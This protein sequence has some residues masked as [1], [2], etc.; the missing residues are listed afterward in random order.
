MSETEKFGR[1]VAVPRHRAWRAA[2]LGG[3]ALGVAT[4]V[5]AGRARGLISGEP[6]NLRDL[7]VTPANI[8][9][10]TNELARMRGAAMKL[11]QL[12]SMDAGDILPPELAQIMAR[13]RA[14]ADFMPPSQ[15]K[16]VLTA[17]WGSDWL[18]GFK[19]FN[20]RPIAAASIGQVH[21]ATL[22]DGRDVAIKV[23]YP[24]VAAS[25]D[26]DVANVASLIRLSGLLPRGFEIDRYVEEARLQ[27]HEETDYLREADHLRTFKGLLG[28]S[29][30]YELPDVYDDLTVPSVLTMSFVES[31]PL[32]AAERCDQATR[33]QIA[34][35]VVDLALREL[36][37][38][39]IVQTDPNFA[40][41]R[42][43]AD[44]GKLVLLDFGATR[45]P[46]EETIETY[47]QLIRAG[48]EDDSDALYGVSQK[49]GVWGADSAPAHVAQLMQMMRLVFGAINENPQF[50]FNDRTL[51]Q[52]LNREGM[53]LAEAGFVPPPVSAD[54]L[55]I[56]RKLAGV[57]LIA[58]NLKATLPVRDMI[59]RRI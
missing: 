5:A 37:E 33:N 20:V 10:V 30:R 6:A 4:N 36:F 41:F 9:R 21:R 27:L 13:L 24:G 23:Q 26:S 39:G 7:I 56:Q 17:A 22:R 29:E 11:G 44:S 34:S 28:R 38:F 51:Q 57:F 18:K 2:R 59:Y 50:D 45:R 58:A 15:L 47:R 1:A 16:K 25:I 48:L 32:E 46:N 3:M 54:V 12:V 8:G 55:F 19:S 31:D 14:E 42:Y 43:N 35:D 52:T 49:L 53:A 40:N